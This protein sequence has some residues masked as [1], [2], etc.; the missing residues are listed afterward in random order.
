ML[1]CGKP[2]LSGETRMMTLGGR[3][4]SG[5]G[6]EMHRLYCEQVKRRGDVLAWA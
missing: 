1:V 6:G 5:E 3:P 2:D 4:A